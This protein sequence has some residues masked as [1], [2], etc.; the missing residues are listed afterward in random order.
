M[1]AAAA[2]SL[3]YALQSSSTPQQSQRSDDFFSGKSHAKESEGVIV[4]SKSAFFKWMESE[5]VPLYTGYSVD[6]LANVK[7]GPWKRVGA[8]GAMI[9]LSGDG[10]IV[11]AY[12]TEIDPGQK[13]IPERHMF[14]ERIYALFGSGETHVWQTGKPKVTARWKRGTLFAVPLNAWHE[15]VNTGSEP[16]RLVSAV[17]AP[18]IIDE[19]RNLDEIFNC[20]YQFT[21]RFDSQPD[22]YKPLDSTVPPEGKRYAYSITNLVP[23]AFTVELFAAGHSPGSK[24]VGTTNHH[25]TMA[26]DTMDSHVEEWQPGVYEIGHRHGPAAQVIFLNGHGYSLTWPQSLGI[27]PFADGHGEKVVRIPWHANTLLVPP[28]GWWHQHFNTSPTPI[29]MLK[30]GE[31]GSRFYLLTSRDTF[32]QVPVPIPYKDEDPK[33]REMFEVELKK[34]GVPSRMPPVEELR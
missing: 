1:S 20:D 5:G 17:S 24:G 27:R 16:V 7:V 9:N 2:P 28:L 25:F 15:H 4:Q 18:I 10:G 22:Y 30:L 8:K 19:Y 33:I 6:D 23:D 26:S 14:D 34:N 3:L 29:R 11:S 21:D 32:N 31:F 13:T 12:I